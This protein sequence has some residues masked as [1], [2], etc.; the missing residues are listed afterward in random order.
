MTAIK[1]KTSADEV[2]NAL[3]NLPRGYDD[4]YKTTMERIERATLVNPNDTTSSLARRT[5]MWNAYSYRA[6]SLAELQEALELDL[7]KPAFRM[8]CPFD[9]QTLLD[10]TAGLVSVDS[11]EQ[12][13][14]LCHAT[15]QEYFDK[16]HETWFPDSASRIARACLQ[17]LNRQEFSFPCEGLREDDELEK[18]TSQHPLL[19]YACT[20]WGNHVSDAGKDE[21]VVKAVDQ[22]LQD[23]GKVAAFIQVAWYLSLESLENWDIRKGANALHIA[24]WFGLTEVIRSLLGH[25]LGVNAQDPAGGRTPLMLAC[26]RGQASTTALLLKVGAS[27]NTLDSAQS[28]ALFEAIVGNHPEVVAALRSK[29]ELNIKEEHLHRAQRTPLMLAATEDFFEIVI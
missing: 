26:R 5:L 16:S 10:V 9:K 23:P 11:D 22:Y 12:H 18:R 27:V 21:E 1:A 20:F 15:A 7:N 4:S 29:P 6:L 14:R 17:Y 24:A 28:T 3:E 2:K 8:S 13:V 19:G 25:G